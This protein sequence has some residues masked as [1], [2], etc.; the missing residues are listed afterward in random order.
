[1]ITTRIVCLQMSFIYQVCTLCVQSVPPRGRGSGLV[2]IVFLSGSDKFKAYDNNS[3]GGSFDLGIIPP[4]RF[5]VAA[6]GGMGPCFGEPPFPV[7]PLSGGDEELYS[8]QVCRT[9]T[10]DSAN[11]PSPVFQ[12]IGIHDSEKTCADARFIA[13]HSK[14]KDA[15][16][17]VSRYI[18]QTLQDF[19]VT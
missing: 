8:P 2:K 1:M 17:N 12:K 7:L 18:D 19:C 5:D 14:N 16:E 10:M 13:Q 15:Y 3:F 9:A 11:D 6:A 4:S